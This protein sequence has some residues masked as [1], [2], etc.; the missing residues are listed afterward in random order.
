MVRKLTVVLCLFS[1]AGVIG[2]GCHAAVETDKGHGA[3]VG[4][5]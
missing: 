3:H 5:G 2:A 4:V 1:L